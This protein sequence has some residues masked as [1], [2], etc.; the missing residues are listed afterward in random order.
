MSVAPT[1]DTV[2]APIRCIIQLKFLPNVDGTVTVTGELLLKHSHL[3]LSDARNV[4]AVNTIIVEVFLSLIYFL[5]AFC[6]F[7]V[8]K[9]ILLALIFVGFATSA[10]AVDWNYSA[11][12]CGNRMV[13]ED[14]VP[15]AMM[16]ARREGCTDVK[17]VYATDNYYVVYGTKVERAVTY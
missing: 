3:S 17:A 2:P 16:L 5:L 8:M 9:R 6:Y 1:I 14:A 4:Y 10:P 12:F 7:A 11:K 13:Y 15:R